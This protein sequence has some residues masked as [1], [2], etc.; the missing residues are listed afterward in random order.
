MLQFILFAGLNIYRFSCTTF[1]ERHL[2]CSVQDK[3]GESIYY[4]GPH[5]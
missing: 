5:E 3:D 2:I 4:H 1:K